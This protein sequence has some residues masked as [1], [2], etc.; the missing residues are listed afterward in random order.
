MSADQDLQEQP[1]LG[2]CTGLKFSNTCLGFQ[3]SEGG[4]CS[5]GSS[6]LS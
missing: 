1:G 4:L 5:M 3:V 6:P 2:D